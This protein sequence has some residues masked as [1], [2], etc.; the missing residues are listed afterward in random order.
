MNSQPSLCE[1]IVYFQR[2][3]HDGPMTWEPE[4]CGLLKLPSARYCDE[5]EARAAQERHH[6]MEFGE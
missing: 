4:R 1:N 3:H 5:C 6:K 2:N